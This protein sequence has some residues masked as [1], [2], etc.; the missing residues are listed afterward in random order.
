MKKRKKIEWTPECEEAFQQL[1]VYLLEASL[2][3]IPKAGE[4]FYLY[5]VVLQW[6]TSLVLI[7][8]ESRVQYP[9]YY[10]SKPLLDVETRY[11]RVEKWT[12]ALIIAARELRPYFQR[13]R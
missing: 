5:L 13:I 3:S 4:V 7:R 2:L 6:S 10:T 12:L 11:L 9:V 8:K 1:K